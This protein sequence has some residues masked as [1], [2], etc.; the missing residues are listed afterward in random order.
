[1]EKKQEMYTDPDSQIED[2]DLLRAVNALLVT[3]DSANNKITAMEMISDVQEECSF[4]ISSRCTS[5]P[6][7]FQ[8]V[9]DMDNAMDNIF[10]GELQNQYF[11]FLFILYN[12]CF[13][14][15]LF[16]IF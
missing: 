6:M 5:Q 12:F 10:D 2:P 4:D 14:N 1:M 13:T 3:K 16:I 9:Q 11:F 15:S 7:T 8:D